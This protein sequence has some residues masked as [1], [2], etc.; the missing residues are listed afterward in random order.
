MGSSVGASGIWLTVRITPPIDSIGQ[1]YVGL[2]I[3]TF[4]SA[5]FSPLSVVTVRELVFV[6]LKVELLTTGTPSMTHWKIASVVGVS[7]EKV[8]SSPSQTCTETGS[9]FREISAGLPISWKS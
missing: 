7:T 8:A 4:T 3:R 5:P 1:A 2:E 9:P 6:P